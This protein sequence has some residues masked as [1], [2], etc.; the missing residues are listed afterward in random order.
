MTCYESPTNLLPSAASMARRVDGG[1]LRLIAI[2]DAVRTL[3]SRDTVSVQDAETGTRRFTSSIDTVPEPIT[4]PENVVDQVPVR[5][6]HRAER[7][8]NKWLITLFARRV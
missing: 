3:E 6:R 4:P 2:I 1:S 8:R 5:G 7:L